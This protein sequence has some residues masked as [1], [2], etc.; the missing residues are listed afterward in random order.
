M[1]SIT[2]VF[3]RRGTTKRANITVSLSL[4]NEKRAAAVARALDRLKAQAAFSGV[5][6]SERLARMILRESRRKP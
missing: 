3:V 5:T 2:R 4:N 6:F 1:A